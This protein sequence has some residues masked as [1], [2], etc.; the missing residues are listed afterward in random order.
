M[1][2]EQAWTEIKQL[3]QDI[4]QWILEN[5]GCIDDEVVECIRASMDKS[6]KDPFA[7]F[8]VISKNTQERADGFKN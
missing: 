8:Y 7:Y 5:R 6:M 2:E 3:K 4:F 1:S